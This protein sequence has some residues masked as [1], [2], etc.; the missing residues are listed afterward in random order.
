LEGVT[1]FRRPIQFA[2]GM[3]S[4]AASL[5]FLHC[6]LAMLRCVGDGR[7]LRV[8][9]SDFKREPALPAGGISP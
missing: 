1:Q 5:I 8:N 2:W 4:L 3:G 9:L 6:R 7:A